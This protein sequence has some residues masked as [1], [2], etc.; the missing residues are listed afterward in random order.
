MMRVALVGYGAWGRHHARALDAAPSATL[1]AI[2]APG[3]DSARE[4][5]AERPQVP[6]HRHLAPVL[7]DPSIEAVV[8]AA[9]NAEHA[10][11]ALAALGAGKHVLLE[12]PMALTLADCDAL[13]A[14]A[15]AAGRVLTIG[16]ELRVSTQ[17]GRVKTL[18]EEGAIGAARHANVSLF[19]FPYRTGSDGWRYDRAAVGSWILEEPVHFFDLLLWYGAAWGPPISIRADAEGDPAMPRALGVTL[20]FAGGQFAT[21]NTVVGGFEHHVALHVMGEAGAIRSLWSAAL[22]RSF[23]PSASLHLFRGRAQPGELAE[24][25]PMAETGEVFELVT[26]AEQAIQGFRVG[27]ALVPPEAGRDAVRCCL[28]AERSAREGREIPWHEAP[29]TP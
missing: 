11:L 20:R 8:I 18:I 5:A 10:R 24:A 14:A 27:R 3:D 19:R 26:Q 16:H 25:I 12:K 1:A 13:A 29:D 28:L 4:A 7:G 21:L 15:K 6:V 23:A 22:D 9:P 2:V 17:W